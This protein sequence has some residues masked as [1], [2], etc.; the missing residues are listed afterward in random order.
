MCAVV[1]FMMI[2]VTAELMRHITQMLTQ[3]ASARLL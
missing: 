3:Y 1:M 2:A